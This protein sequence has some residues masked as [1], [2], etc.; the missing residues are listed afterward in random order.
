MTA[1]GKERKAVF[2]DAVKLIQGD[3]VV[4]SDVMV[5]YFREEGQ[6]RDGRRN[7]S[8]GPSGQ[9]IHLIEATGKVIIK[10]ATGRATCRHALYYKD[11]EKIVLTGSPIAWQEGTRVSGRKIIMYLKENRSVVEGGSRVIIMDQEGE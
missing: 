5:V 6:S 3:L 8:T 7:G 1:N 9:K 11:E 2:Q 4:R 10:K